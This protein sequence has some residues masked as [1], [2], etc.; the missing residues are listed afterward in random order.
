[1]LEAMGVDPMLT[2]CAVRVSLGGGNSM[3]QVENFLKALGKVTEELRRM[4]MV[5]A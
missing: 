3:E 5:T 1:V 2:R 4:S